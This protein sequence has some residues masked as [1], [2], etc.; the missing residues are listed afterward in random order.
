MKT[1]SGR[2]NH[3]VWATPVAWVLLACVAVR[4]GR[5]GVFEAVLAS[6]VIVLSLG[7]ART[8]AGNRGGIAG[9][10]AEVLALAIAVVWLLT[11]PPAVR[12]L[13][14]TAGSLGVAALAT[15]GVWPTLDRERRRWLVVVLAAVVAA[16]TATGTFAAPLW[17]FKALLILLSM[18][19]VAWVLARVA[20]PELALAAVLAAAVT[21]GPAHTLAWLL[22]VIVAA[23]LWA[24]DSDN[25]RLL[26]ILAVSAAALPPAG[27]VIAAALLV[28]AMRHTRARS[29]LLAV[30]AIAVVAWW[31]LP[32]GTTIS[33][34]PEW[35][36]LVTAFPVTL[37]SLPFLLPAAFVA[38]ATRHPG[39]LEA[40]DGL[41][42]GLMLSPWLAGGPWGAAAIASLWLL[43]LPSA[44]TDPGH[45]QWIANMLPWSVAAPAGLL[46]LAPWGGVNAAPEATPLLAV[47]WCVALIAGRVHWPVA[48]V[49]W[50]LP[51]AGLAWTTP[52]VGVERHLAAGESMVMTADSSSGW[53][54]EIGPTS[55]IPIHP[56]SEVLV[57]PN[58]DISP[59]L[60]GGECPTGGLPARDPLLVTA[61]LGRSIS[62]TMRGVAVRPNLGDT[63][64]Q[65]E[66]DLRLRVET[67]D[68]WRSRRTRVLVLLLGSVMLLTAAHFANP[69]AGRALGVATGAAVAGGVAAGCAAAPLARAAFHS[70]PDLAAA[71]LVGSW[72]AAYGR[73]GHRRFVAGALLLVPLALAQPFL[74][75]P[76]GDEAYH[77]VIL[78]SLVEDHDLAISDNIDPDDPATAPYLDH[79]DSLIH[80]PALAFLTL[81]G[82][83]IAGHAGSLGVAALMVAAGLALTARRALHL[84]LPRRAVDA[85][86]L[87][88]LFTYP[89]VTFATQLWPAPVGIL[90]VGI[91]LEI[92]AR[93]WRIGAVLTTA[94]AILVKVRFGL[95][96]LPMLVAAVLRDSSRRRFYLVAAGAATAL[97]AVAVL[98]LGV[99]RHRLSELIPPDPMAPV[100]ALWGLLWDAAGGMAFANP[101]WLV[102]L[103]A[104]PTL[105]RRSTAGERALVI[106]AALT[107]AALL[108]R[109][110]WYGGGS[111]PARYLAPL[112]PLTLLALAALL[113]SNRGRRLASLALPWAAV[114]GWTAMTRPL[115]LYNPVDGGWWFADR[116]GRLLEIPTRDV[117]P[118]LLRPGPAAVIV[119][120]LMVVVALLWISRSWRGAA[121]ATALGLAAVLVTGAIRRESRVHAEDPHVRH[122]AGTAEPPSGTFFRAVHGIG[123]RLPPGTALEIPWR[124]PLSRELAAR[125]RV[126]GPRYAGGIMR[127]SWNDGLPTFN[128]VAGDWWHTVPLPAPTGLGRGVLRV[129]WL[130]HEDLPA[131]DLV[132]DLVGVAP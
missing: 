32:Q 59:I 25:G 99:G 128:E 83:V 33:A 125:V 5:V 89:V 35:S 72:A 126:L 81:P 112:A 56:G 57:F 119:P 13:R 105:W 115:W 31:R 100:I 122:H 63:R 3:G 108:P 116:L 17:F 9:R 107:V 39:K 68:R 52:V 117:F 53:V 111:P 109:G 85:A 114:V 42:V 38:L 102:G 104:V 48:R 6:V 94:V 27:L 44:R 29:I 55:S 66:I 113:C 2:L 26:P 78:Q 62:Q 87:A 98:G 110:E 21:I 129:D 127:A 84:G 22:P 1:A 79:G 130:E 11:D 67:F 41:A 106:G 92:T 103:V 82:Y 124:P 14:V 60:A 73:F 7:V 74:R 28:V 12:L 77:V 90:A 20:S 118:T 10:L 23:A 93:G 64:I 19:T 43:T 45:G 47:G 97:T 36:A 86:W 40:R 96:A 76:V 121:A 131:G 8:I 91:L 61:G 120:I 51:I 65:T 4:V 58:T 18:V 30:T 69:T 80:S 49:A 34:W 75:G 132:V 54:F 123:W 46:L 95:I 101:L 15:V 70:G 88:A 24:L 37:T 50:L 16:V 71:V